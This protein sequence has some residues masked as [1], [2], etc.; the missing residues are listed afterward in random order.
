MRSPEY[1]DGSIILSTYGELQREA[2]AFGRGHYS[3]ILVIGPPGTGKTKAF[4]AVRDET[5][6]LVAVIGGNAKPLATYAQCY[7]NS[8][9]LLVFD[10][11]KGLWRSDNIY[12]Q[13]G[14]IYSLH[15][16]F[17][18]LVNRRFVE[19]KAELARLM[20]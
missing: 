5:P 11:A 8:H 1:P 16:K 13:L 20:Q 14:D 6:H 17:A 9:K 19:K 2:T 4:E 3:E 18:E 7:F 12:K 15:P 10:D